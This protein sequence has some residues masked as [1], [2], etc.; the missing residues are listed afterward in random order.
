MT[1]KYPSI[2]T[3]FVRDNT[4]NKLEFGTIREYETH[5]VREWVLTEKVDGTNVRAIISND[6]IE[7]RGRTDKADLPKDLIAAVIASFPEH[8]VLKE[9]FG[10]AE[11]TPPVTFYGEGYGAG[12]QKGGI[13]SDK[14]EFIVFDIRFGE[15]QYWHDIN[16]VF[17]ICTQLGIR[18]VPYLGNILTEQI[19]KTREEL[20]YTIPYSYVAY[21]N[22][23]KQVEAEGIVAKPIY[24]LL[25][26]F[27]ERV[28]WKLTF[29]EFR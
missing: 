5:A 16:S 12:I 28:M 1:T 2:E 15:N 18:H 4:T 25:N 7:V 10:I 26:K 24:T 6:G 11:G 19:P 21:E 14:K 17:E 3:V 27:G 22:T 23:G 9:F 20:L 8:E 29:R 13:Y